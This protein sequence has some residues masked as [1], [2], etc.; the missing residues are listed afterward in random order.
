MEESNT[1][2]QNNYFYNISFLKS[3]FLGSSFSNSKSDYRRITTNTK[4]PFM[5]YIF[6]ESKT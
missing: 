1:G 5:E 4:R 6:P 2:G 3:Y